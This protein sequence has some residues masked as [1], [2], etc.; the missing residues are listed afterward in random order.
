MPV[1]IGARPKQAVACELNRQR[2]DRSRSSNSRGRS[3]LS[4]RIG[5]GAAELDMDDRSTPIRP[6]SGSVRFIDTPLGMG[7]ATTLMSPR[8]YSNLGAVGGEV[9]ELISGPSA[10]TGAAAPLALPLLQPRERHH[11]MNRIE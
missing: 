2:M 11:A 6:R 4:K 3:V 7:P 8:R 1:L 5:R 10:P 9:L